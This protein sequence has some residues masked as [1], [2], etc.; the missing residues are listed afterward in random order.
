M[1]SFKEQHQYISR[2]IEEQNYELA[3]LSMQ[4]LMQAMPESP[5]LV[6]SMG[7]LEVLTG[8]PAAAVARWKGLELTELRLSDGQL[9]EITQTLTTYQTI[10]DTYNTSLQ[11]IQTNKL[12]EALALLAPLMPETP[13]LPLPL[14]LYQVYYTLLAALG[15]GDKVLESVKRAPVYVNS[16]AEV[17]TLVSRLQEHQFAADSAKLIRQKRVWSKLTYTAASISVALVALAGFLLIQDRE[18]AAP[19]AVPVI[20]AAVEPVANDF[21]EE[22]AVQK[23]LVQQLEAQKSGL[24]NQ[25]SSVKDHAEKLQY[26]EKLVELTGNNIEDMVS[27]A[28]ARS[29]RQGMEYYKDSDYDKAVELLTESNSLG[30]QYYF[31]DDSLYYLIQALKKSGQ[32]ELADQSYDSFL[33][34]TTEPFMQS[35]Y[36]DD[37]LLEKAESF[38][39]VNETVQAQSLLKQII[40]HYPDQWTAD[41]ARQIYK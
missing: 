23:D 7:I 18:P 25:L 30:W 26:I 9:Q 27:Q 41:K 6:R 28:A 22:L 37:V 32:Y 4:Q 16:S 31:S 36:R 20:A 34:N 15:K 2:L 39:A 14:K 19:A 3:K 33:S 40:E 35:P 8:Y 21:Q 5:E 17:I 1:E 38:I 29:Y 12:E 13:V 10:Y 11:L 24:Q